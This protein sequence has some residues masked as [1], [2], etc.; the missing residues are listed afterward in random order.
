MKEQE[1]EMLEFGYTDVYG[2]DR[3]YGHV[4]ITGLS[5]D[6]IN[7]IVEDVYDRME[8][9]LEGIAME[10]DDDENPIGEHEYLQEKLSALIKQNAQLKEKV[11]VLKQLLREEFTSGD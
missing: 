5:E 7:A 11:A 9:E 10:V 6:E 8:E 2:V 1:R 3:I 4:D